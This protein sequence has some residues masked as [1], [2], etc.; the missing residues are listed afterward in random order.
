MK[1]FSEYI[2]IYYSIVV[3]VSNP[4]PPPRPSPPENCNLTGHLFLLQTYVKQCI[5]GTSPIF[6]DISV[7]SSASRTKM[8]HEK[9]YEWIHGQRKPFL[10]FIFTA[11]NIHFQMCL[12]VWSRR[13]YFTM[14]KKFQLILLF[15]LFI[16]VKRIIPPPSYIRVKNTPSKVRLSLL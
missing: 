10:R 9:L 8:Y 15:L 6:T 7:T 16:Q 13:L 3:Y 5:L 4:L 1:Q 11:K 2:C 14:Q 12:R